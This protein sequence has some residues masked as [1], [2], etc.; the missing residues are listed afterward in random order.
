MSRDPDVES[1]LETLR[2]SYREN[3]LHL[4]RA[5]V[6]LFQSGYYPYSSFLAITAMEEA[7]KLVGLAIV[8][9]NPRHD[10]YKEL[11]GRS[12]PN[13]YMFKRR[14]EGFKG[15]KPKLKIALNWGRGKDGTPHR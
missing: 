7:A 2:D 8:W 4:I 3:S 9:R 15:H 1:F 13:G 6:S 14:K 5:A 10:E 11:K 12:L